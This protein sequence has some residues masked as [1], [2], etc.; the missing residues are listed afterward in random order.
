MEGKLTGDRILILTLSF[1]AGHVRAAE[2][3][4]AEF[5]RQRPHAEIRI[6]DAL[7]NCRFLFRVFYVWTYWLMIRFVPGVWGRFF[8]SRVKRN[9]QQTAPVW[10]WRWGCRR[11]FAEIETF[12]PEMI[13]CC[14]V[15]ASELAVIATR[16]GITKARIVNVITDFEAEPIWVKPEASAYAVSNGSV[17][18]QLEKWGASAGLIHVCGI[19]ID[20]RFGIKYE[21]DET[22]QKFELDDRPIVLLMGGGMGPTRMDAVAA[23]LLASGRDLQI[24]A[25]PGRD[26]RM[27][28]KLNKLRNTANSGL[29]VVNWTNDVARLMQAADLLITKAGGLTLAEA[30][31]CGAPL[32]LFDSI[33]GPE[34]S[35]ALH[36]TTAGAAVMTSDSAETALV[37]LDILASDERREA[38]SA[39]AIKLAQPH[40]AEDIVD[41]AISKLRPSKEGGDPHATMAISM[42]RDTESPVL[43]LTISNGFGHIRLAN[44]LASAIREENQSTTVLI[45][46]VADYMTPFARFTHVTAYLWLVKHLPGVW[47]YIDRFQ[48]KQSGTS[49]DWFYRRACRA[50]FDLAREIRPTA[51]VATEVGC[52]EI[53]AL[54]KRDL[55]LRVPLAAVNGEMDADR[56]WV[57]PE[58]DLYSCVTDECGDYFIK[59]GAARERVEIW[60]PTISAG[61]GGLR[62]RESERLAIC[63]KFDLDPTKPLVLLAGGS[64]GIGSIEETARK[65]LDMAHPSTQLLL[66]TGRNEPLRSRCE[67]LA[68]N[69]A[70]HDR[71]RVLSWTDP[72]EMPSLM[73]TADLMVS[74]LGSMFYEAIASELPIVALEPPPGAERLQYHLL[75][76]WGVGR[77]V[78]NID[79]MAGTVADLLK[80]PEKLAE[81]RTN[82]RKRK[83]S[84]AAQ[85]VA[86]WLVQ[87]SGSELWN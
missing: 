12:Q 67:R 35:N 79:E 80:N 49:P 64:E 54:I 9:D 81:M 44:A 30:A 86:R 66:L 3:I 11:V 85:Q 57:Q 74:K 38:M 48:K 27:L 2:V 22:R 43:I 61:F 68:K 37:S 15:G 70:Q 16:D 73:G 17:R 28:R 83:P 71:L 42:P 60:G 5:A 52:C 29:H 69:K 32:V 6:V 55:S 62:N 10:A 65:L 87:R 19:P 33:P 58:V 47:A 75:N 59:N 1:G 51:L 18:R 40:A 63:D 36:F 46:D 7:E 34:N 8:A 53:A 84:G 20:P 82:A 31:A 45:V 14:E 21:V 24:V 76:E 26:A 56:A 39:C 41:L 77:A 4:S 78:H 23:R 72:D 25:L 13:I 50:L